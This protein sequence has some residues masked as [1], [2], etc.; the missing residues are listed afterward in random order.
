LAGIEDRH[1]EDR[2]GTGFVASG[3]LQHLGYSL[4]R[5]Q[6]TPEHAEKQVD[7]CPLPFVF[8]KPET[9]G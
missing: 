6:A 7:F 1:S 2:R 9:G 5:Q 4:G 3:S 8:C